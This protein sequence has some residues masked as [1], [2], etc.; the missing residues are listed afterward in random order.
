MIKV[1]KVIW[2]VITGLQN[3]GLM[4]VVMAKAWI[5]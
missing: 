1:L 2:R 4:I 3:Y 5:C